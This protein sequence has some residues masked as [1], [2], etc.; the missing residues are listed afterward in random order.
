MFLPLDA[1]RNASHFDRI[2][3]QDWFPSRKFLVLRKPNVLYIHGVE[4]I[5]RS[6]RLDQQRQH[7]CSLHKKALA[8]PSPFD[9]PLLLPPALAP[10]KNLIVVNHIYLC[11]Y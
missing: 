9:R 8:P 6:R 5:G 11:N 4:N 2:C 3:S 7:L 10:E 1:L